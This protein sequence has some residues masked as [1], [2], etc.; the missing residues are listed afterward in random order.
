MVS[1]TIADGN[2][3]QKKQKNRPT[4]GDFKAV[5]PILWEK[6]N[7]VLNPLSKPSIGAAAWGLQ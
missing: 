1:N 4:N 2:T 3:K 7:Q 6:G 5:P